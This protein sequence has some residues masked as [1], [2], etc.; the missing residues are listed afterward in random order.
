[1]GRLEDKLEHERARNAELKEQVRMHGFRKAGINT[2]TGVGKAAAKLYDGAP[3][4]AAIRE[5]FDA[6]FGTDESHD[7]E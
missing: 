4:P 2:S 3:D 6:E 1:M 5:F 7:D